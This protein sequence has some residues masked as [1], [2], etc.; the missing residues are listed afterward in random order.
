MIRLGVWLFQTLLRLVP[1]D[2][3]AEHGA[4][5]VED[6]TGLLRDAGTRGLGAVI[7]A[8]SRA[9]A[10]LVRR[11]TYEHWLRR[12]RVNRRENRIMSLPHDVRFAIRGFA[13]QPGSS[14]LLLFT[15]TLGMASAMAVFGLINGIV[16]RPLP[17]P[18][19]DRFV[20]LNE[21]APRWNLTY[22][23]INY[24]DFV[25]WRRAVR[26]FEGM[27][28][29][30]GTSV[31]LGDAT[32][33]ERV[34]GAKVTFD[35][36]A[37][38][39]I[40]PILGRVFR[41]DDDRLG[42]PKVVILGEKLWRRRFGAAMGVVGQ[43]VRVNA[44][45]YTVIGVVPRSAEF[46]AGYQLWLP[47]QEDP[48]QNYQSYSYEGVGRLK[49]GT[50]LAAAREDLIQAHRPIWAA[51]DTSH[52]VSPVL[53]SLR[54]ELGADYRTLVAALAI[55]VVLVL[56]CACANVASSMFARAIFRQRELAVR[57]ALGADPS[58]LSRQLLVES[59]VLAAAAGLAGMIVGSWGLEIFA[60]ALPDLLPSWIR[61]EPDW[62]TAAAA[63]AFVGGTTIL[64]GVA[65]A[66]SA[67]RQDA[68]AVL[69]RPAT[70]ASLSAPHRRL[71]N[72]FVVAEVGLASVLLVGS[73]M[74]ARAYQ[75]VR[76]IDPGIQVENALTFQVSL[77]PLR[78][79]D[80]SAI[81]L[82]HARLLAGLEAIP[83]VDRAGLVSCLPLAGCHNG[84]FFV[85]EGGEPSP[86]GAP[87]PVILTQVATPGYF[88]AI[89]ARLTR[90]RRF[91][92][93]PLRAVV[94]SEDFA[95]LHWPNR[96]PVGRRIRYQ[97]SDTTR[98]STVIGVVGNIK[99]YG[100]DR[101]T[102]PT[103]Y[104]NTFG[105]APL[106]A[107]AAVVRTLGP[108]SAVT[109]TVRRL[110]RDLDPELPIYAVA[111]MED[112]IQKSLGIRRVMAAVLAFFAT[113]TL[114]LAIGGIYAVLSYVVGRRRAELGVRLALGANPGQ[115][116]R[117]VMGQGLRLVA[118]GAIIGFPVAIAGAKVLSANVVGV[119]PWDLP[120]LV[121]SATVM[122][123]VG[124]IAAMVPGR[125]AARVDPRVAL[126]SN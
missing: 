105:A 25:Q 41:A 125:R 118:L 50:S 66:L 78:Y 115:V 12:D 64:F 19:S 110:V 18:D 94:V 42:G 90:G 38:L 37:V 61:L 51:S 120:V 56:L 101:P 81:R 48:A 104:F 92:S 75:R 13:R 5:M 53:Q 17:F 60:K 6:L 7:L 85:A 71:L 114:F 69:G 14:G 109:E 76:T 122:T 100:L 35:W 68:G 21:T 93:E 33:P 84:N 117:M 99:H 40:Q 116:V 79:P 31:N 24:P 67:R 121:A 34:L 16:L 97:G 3:R 52:T 73:G 44:E 39:G 98:W 72:G 8:W 49:P 20:Y 23:S 9:V 36:A 82:F 62:V 26:T 70:Q 11:T 113:L 46:P 88:E 96:D 45:P 22:T 32:G 28:L 91:G 2:L 111:T 102:R 123:I 63:L 80:S 29:Y 54:D 119:N 126:S 103:L 108:P 65:P 58:Q 107:F 89:G 55:G 15:L 30:T 47:L 74:L 1:G 83:G 106:D 87:N 112:T 4:A 86:P 43:T 77:P 57:V 95:R 59:L 27:A 10:D 124:V